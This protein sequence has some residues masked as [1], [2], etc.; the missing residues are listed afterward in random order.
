MSN[1]FLTPDEKLKEGSFLAAAPILAAMKECDP[2]L[3][4]YAEELIQQLGQELDVESRRATIALLAEMLFP[5]NDANGLPGMDL[6]EAE[7]RSPEVNPEAATVL[8]TMDA[9]EATFADRLQSL[10]DERGLTQSALSSIVS[11]GQPAIS[12]MLTRKCRPQRRTI[13]KFAD[14]LGVPPARLWPSWRE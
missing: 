10:M 7:R 3:R 8:Q 14:A 2:E 13:R 1:V 11:L 4:E 6:E 9:E 5:S 12:M